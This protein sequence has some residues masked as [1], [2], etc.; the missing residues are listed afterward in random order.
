MSTAHTPRREQDDA[1][2]VREL[3]EALG[4][5][6]AE[7]RSIATASGVVREITPRSCS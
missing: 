6:P 4:G 1:A 2:R 5:S 7:R 3:D